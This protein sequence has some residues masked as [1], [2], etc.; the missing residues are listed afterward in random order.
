[1]LLLPFLSFAPFFIGEEEGYFAEQGL[2]IEFV[3]ANTADEA[4]PILAQGELDVVGGGIGPGLLNGLAR[5]ARIKIVAGKGYIAPKGC[6]PT[7]L[8]AR[9]VT[10]EGGKLEGPAQLQ[11]R[12]IAM[13]PTNIDG[14][15]VDKVLGT[16]DLTLEDVELVDIPYPVRAEALDKGTIDVTVAGEP[17]LTRMMRG[18]QA[19][20]WVPAW[21]VIPDYQL[22]H[23]A[24]GPTLLDES[25]DVGRRFMVA[26]LKAV[27][28]LK[29]GKTERNLEIL[30]KHTGLDRPLLSEACWYSFREGGWINV[31]S[32]FDFQEWAL[33]K[34]YLD[35]LVAEEQFWEPSFVEYANQVLGASAE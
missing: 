30:A 5:G 9:R 21:Q 18:G 13:Y 15:F 20:A 24:Y 27:G 2:Q 26:Y 3:K 7:A 35:S 11:G 12:R 17:W 29:E 10:V 8:V 28:Q 31:Q 16:V 34:G 19:V 32:V 33:E 1:V 14:Y 6:S 4:I 23:I 22:A 25:P